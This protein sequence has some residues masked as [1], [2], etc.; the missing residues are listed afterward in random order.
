[1]NDVER[2]VGAAKRQKLSP[3]NRK[4]RGAPEGLLVSTSAG[5]KSLLIKGILRSRKTSCA[6]T[7]TSDVAK[8]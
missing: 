8:T 3:E 7:R 6:V 1:M 4:A 5:L 2:L